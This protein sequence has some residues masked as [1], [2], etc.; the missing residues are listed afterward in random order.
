M[1]LEIILLVQNSTRDRYARVR[2]T[3]MLHGMVPRSF[4]TDKKAFRNRYENSRNYGG[5]E[6]FKDIK[7]LHLE[8]KD[9]SKVIMKKIREKMKLKPSQIYDEIKTEYKKVKEVVKK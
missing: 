5:S 2:H 3:S 6:V 7:N 4:K 1:V 9:N 8:I